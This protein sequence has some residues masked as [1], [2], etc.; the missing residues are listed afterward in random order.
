MSAGFILPVASANAPLNK[1]GRNKKTLSEGNAGRNRKTSSET[2][3][4]KRKMDT[5]FSLIE[6]N[7]Q[8]SAST[9]TSKDRDLCDIYGELVALKL[10]RLSERDREYCMNRFDNMLFEMQFPRTSAPPSLLQSSRHCSPS[11]YSPGILSPTFSSASHSP[12]GS[13]SSN[14][15]RSPSPQA[16]MSPHYPTPPPLPYTSPNNNSAPQ[17]PCT[18]NSTDFQ[19]P[20]LLIT[21]ASNVTVQSSSAAPSNVDIVTN[22]STTDLS[23][24]R[25]ETLVNFFQSFAQ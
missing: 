14:Y 4:L 2:D 1:L 20:P 15:T 16:A 12:Y 19:Y 9:T 7:V 23:G 25:D 5:A 6:A 3:D 24:K 22:T 13:R 21:P 8:K 18:L 10:R 17:V 11:P